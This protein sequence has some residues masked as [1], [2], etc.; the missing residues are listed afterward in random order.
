[1]PPAQRRRQI[2]RR[3]PGYDRNVAPQTASLQ[4]DDAT[5]GRCGRHR[6]L[7]YAFPRGPRGASPEAG[8]GPR[9]VGSAGLRVKTIARAGFFSRVSVLALALVL[10]WAAPASDRR[11]GSAWLTRARARTRMRTTT[12]MVPCAK[13]STLSSGGHDERHDAARAVRPWAPACAAHGVPRGG[14]DFHGERQHVLGLSA[15]HGPRERSDADGRHGDDPE[16][17]RWLWAAPCPTE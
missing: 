5:T 1:M 13:A 2:P 17:S 7:R 4:G 9:P 8:A 6:P 3:R 14:L 11:Q 15:S 12:L 16:A 10:A